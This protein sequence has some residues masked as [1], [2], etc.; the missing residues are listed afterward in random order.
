MAVLVLNLP[1]GTRKNHQTQQGPDRESNQRH[2]IFI[3][4]N[5][6]PKP[7]RQNN[8]S[9]GTAKGEINLWGITYHSRKTL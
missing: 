9:T 6:N 1:E 5:P 7:I 2:G 8:D 4:P 3:N